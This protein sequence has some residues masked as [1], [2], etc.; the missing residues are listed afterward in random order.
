MQLK[1]KLAHFLK[2]FSY[3]LTA[4]MHDMI[5]KKAS[6]LKLIKGTKII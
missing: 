3:L 4:D 2:Y 5:T 6:A 1:Q